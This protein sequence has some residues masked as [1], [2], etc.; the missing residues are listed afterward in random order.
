MF[1]QGKIA[2]FGIPNSLK[3]CVIFISIY[4]TDKCGRGMHNRWLEPWSGHTLG[5]SPWLRFYS[6]TAKMLLSSLLVEILLSRWCD[7]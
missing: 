3:Y 4:T 1:A 7:L 2:V 6:C 5:T